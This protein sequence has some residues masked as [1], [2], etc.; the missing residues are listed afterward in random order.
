[1]D[2]HTAL[3]AEFTMTGT[4]ES[5]LSEHHRQML[6]TFLAL[7]EAKAAIRQ[8][9]AGEINIQK[10]MRQLTVAAAGDNAAA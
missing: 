9:E 10:A 8:F 7:E 1:M 3:T 2:V 5:L 6:R 4:E